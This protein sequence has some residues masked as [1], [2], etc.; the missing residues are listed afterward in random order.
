MNG[1]L[2]FL[3]ELLVN[4]MI[5]REVLRYQREAGALELDADARP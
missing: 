1:L 5:A 4:P 3:R 2:L